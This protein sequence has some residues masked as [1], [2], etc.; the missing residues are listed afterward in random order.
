MHR[1]LKPADYVRMPW[2]NGGGQTTEIVV[3]PAGATL[4]EFDWRVSI[5]D[6][7]AD[8]PFSQLRRRRP[9]RWC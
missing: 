8:G 5:A 1:L 3:H 9:R 2:K 6:V 7:D 4:A